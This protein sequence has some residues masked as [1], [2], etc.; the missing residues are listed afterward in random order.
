MITYNQDPNPTPDEMKKFLM[1]VFLYI[2][3]VLLSNIFYK[4]GFN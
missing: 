4:Y 2:I 1:C 3:I